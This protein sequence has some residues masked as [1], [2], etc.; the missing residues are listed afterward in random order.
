MTKLP[1][2]FIAWRLY[3]AN[4]ENLHKDELDMPVPGPNEILVHVDA[5]G[6]CFSDMKII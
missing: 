1:E 6:L 3:G 2:K 5:V 4:L